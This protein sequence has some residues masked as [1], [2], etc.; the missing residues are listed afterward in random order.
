M[1]GL[2]IRG[3][4]Y[5]LSLNTEFETRT[6]ELL[7]AALVKGHVSHGYRVVMNLG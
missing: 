1:P 5:Q 6:D 4:G 7:A 2:R 3:R